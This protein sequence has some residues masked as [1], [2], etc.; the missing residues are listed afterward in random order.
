[1]VIRTVYSFKLRLVC[2]SIPVGVNVLLRQDM[3]LL[4]SLVVYVIHKKEVR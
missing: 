2:H 4:L 3:A 1:M